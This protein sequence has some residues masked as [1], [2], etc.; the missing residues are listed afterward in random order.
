[1]PIAKIRVLESRYDEQGSGEN[2]SF[3]QGLAQRAHISQST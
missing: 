2:F 3:G 1:M